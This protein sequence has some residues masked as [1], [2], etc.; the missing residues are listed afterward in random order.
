MK[1]FII[2]C[3]ILF[4]SQLIHVILILISKIINKIDNFCVFF[5]YYLY[6]IFKL[7]VYIFFFYFI[8]LR[9][10]LIRKYAK[11]NINFHTHL[12]MHS[13]KN[14]KFYILRESNNNKIL[15]R[16]GELFLYYWIQAAIYSIYIYYERLRI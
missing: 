2:L 5:Q 12:G 13:L 9:V 15:M 4:L 3:F 14:N 1:N 16:V 7:F 10:I 6:M 8:F 11:G